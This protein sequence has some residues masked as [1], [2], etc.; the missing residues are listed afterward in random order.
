MLKLAKSVVDLV[1]KRNLDR[2]PCR[3]K[4]VAGRISKSEARKKTVP[5]AVNGLLLL[6]EE[7]ARRQGEKRNVDS[8]NNNS[9]GIR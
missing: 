8:S 7:N 6:L 9:M 2:I 1:R 5:K 4:S 3:P